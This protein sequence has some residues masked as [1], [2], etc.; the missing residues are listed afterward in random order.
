[1]VWRMAL[2]RRRTRGTPQALAAEIE[3]GAPSVEAAA[4]EADNHKHLHQ[5]IETLPDELRQ[6]LILS[7]VQEMT[8]AEIG[9]ILDLPDATVRNRLLCARQLLREKWTGLH[10][11][12]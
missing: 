6:P 2:D 10:H 9:A 11:A 4:L 5:L 7:T 12:R 8:S 3:S 1:M